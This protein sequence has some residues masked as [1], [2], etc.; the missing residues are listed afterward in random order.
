M[1]QGRQADG[2]AG[3]R[4]GIRAGMLNMTHRGGAAR[5]VLLLPP[6]SV[7]LLGATTFLGAHRESRR[8]K[9]HVLTREE[10]SKLNMGNISW[11]QLQ[12]SDL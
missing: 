10:K 2:R 4:P 8:K 9:K 6:S 1:G 11:M 3:G 5:A 12:I 7:R